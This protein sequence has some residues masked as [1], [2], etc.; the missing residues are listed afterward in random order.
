M[1]P[2][3]T[4]CSCIAW[5]SAAWVL[6]GVRLIS[7]ASTT[8]AKTGPWTKRKARRAGGG[9][10]LDDLGAGDVARHQVGGEL[11]A[12]ERQVQRLGDGLDHQRL[13]QAG[14]ADQQGVAAGE[15]RGEDAVHDVLLADDALGDLGAEPA[16]GTHQ[17]L[18]LLDVVATLEAR[19]PRL[20]Q[21]VRGR[22]YLLGDPPPPAAEEG[23]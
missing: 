8:L 2:A 21:T 11:D 3:V 17:A 16:D 1:P 7:S 4:W 13:G 15:D 6:G 23:P 20:I 5:S 14:H 22:G 10:L 12:V 19:G 18:Q 9:V